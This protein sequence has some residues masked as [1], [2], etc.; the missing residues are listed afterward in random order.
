MKFNFKILTVIFIL[1]FAIL[2]ILQITNPKESGYFPRKVDDRGEVTVSAKPLV[3]ED[4]FKI[5][6]YIDTHTVDLKEDLK[7]VAY[8][9][10]ES[11]RHDPID[12]IGD[13]SGGHHRSG[14]LFFDGNFTDFS[15]HIESIG[16][17]S[18]KFNW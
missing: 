13:P 2:L 15:L 14:S 9:T 1:V 5:V 12:W 16:G 18:K 6:L 7:K 11:E 8:I 17:E 10:Q 4:G 3:S